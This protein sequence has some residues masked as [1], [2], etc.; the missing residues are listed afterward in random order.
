MEQQVS[1][2]FSQSLL[3]FC[4]IFFKF[5]F[6]ICQNEEVVPQWLRTAGWGAGFQGGVWIKKIPGIYFLSLY[7][8]SQSYVD[9]SFK[10]AFDL[11][12]RF[13]D[14]EQDSRRAH[15]LETGRNPSCYR[16]WQG[17][18]PTCCHRPTSHA[19]VQLAV[20]WLLSPVCREKWW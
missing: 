6:I 1:K 15:V 16:A 10:N 13:L 8:C 2:A 20:T 9:N 19:G 7:R 4:Y 11:Q 3:F 18:R 14:L 17:V 12:L 5:V